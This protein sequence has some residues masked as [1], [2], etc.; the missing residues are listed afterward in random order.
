MTRDKMG[1]VNFFYLNRDN[2]WRDFQWQGLEL[3]ANGILRLAS[4]PSVVEPSPSLAEQPIPD[5]PAGVAIGG[6]GTLY[7]TDP[8]HHLLW[9]I[10]PC[11]RAAC[12]WHR[13]RT[14]IPCLG[15]EGSQ[16][17]QFRQPRGVL[18]HLL[19]QAIFVAD[20]G[21][22]RL[23]IFHPQSF[24][25]LGIWGQ[26][27]MA[28]EPQ[29]SA[30]PGHFNTP[31]TL[32]CDVAGN[33]YVVD[34]GNQR[35]QKFDLSGNVIESFWD[36]LRAETTLQQPSDIAVVQQG[37][38]TQVYILDASQQAIF[39]VNAEGDFR[40]QL[41]LSQQLPSPMGLAVTQEAIFVGDN[42]RQRVFK[43]T[44]AGEFVGEA[45]G[46][47]GSVAA[48][49]VENTPTGM[50]FASGLAGN[51][52]L[53]LHPG[54]NAF[55][56]VLYLDR[57]YVNSGIVWGG[58]FHPRENAVQWHQ[59]KA[60]VEALQTGTHLQFF[61][62][63]SDRDIPPPA[64][65]PTDPIYPFDA[66]IWKAM[67]LDSLEGLI[68]GEA[69]QYLWVGV[70]FTGEG[71]ASP[72]LEQIRVQFD[73]DSYSQYLPAIY[74][75]NPAYRQ[76]LEQLLS[77]FES[78]F[79]DVE[80][81]IASLSQYFDAQAIPT[82]WLPWLASWLALQ[83]DE[84]APEP[85]Q[86]QAIAQAPIWHAQR[87]TARGL[88]TALRFYANVDARIEEPILQATWWALPA[89]TSACQS[90]QQTSLLGFT[91]RLAPAEA[92]GAVVGTTATVD[93]SHLIDG[94]AYGSP[95]YEQLAHQFSVQIYR[96]QI[97][98]T[99]TLAQIREIIEREKP[100]HT[101]YQICLVEPQMRVGW[102]ARVGI[103]TIVAGSPPPT[104]IGES[105]GNTKMILAGD[106]TGQIGDRSRIGQTTRLGDR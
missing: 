12:L 59:F 37:D 38:E 42:Q 16:A 13:S 78:G 39:V 72:R 50:S 63:T 89:N 83:L 36:T 57:A 61:F 79:T 29:P 76:T 46:Y 11:V 99:K 90:E 98:N 68:L 18:F 53:W 71:K 96:G 30:E 103:D 101:T 20:S 105:T 47:H 58:S 65:N 95:L 64:P 31:W 93:R 55:P 80:A 94:E 21:N 8:T 22:H 106:P 88:Q 43:F 17:T 91:T 74:R 35:V 102:Q 69:K 6:D 73:Y 52:F 66:T 87:G 67:P 32:A 51:Q 3:E 9:R 77:L 1:R 41:S 81:A 82:Q 54:G 104:R 70:H 10:D 49:T 44:I 86:R 40:Q 28:S 34:Y 15:S 45:Q 33:I 24:Q 56:V 48:L 97:H 60:K 92:Q 26:S 5:A 100:I 14:P 23:Q 25:L 27:D 19:R 62:Y 4:L 85:K 7:F 84:N 2:C 75:E